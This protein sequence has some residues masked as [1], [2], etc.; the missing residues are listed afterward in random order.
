MIPWDFLGWGME[1]SGSNGSDGFFGWG[2]AAVAMVPMNLRVK[3]SSLGS[4][5]EG[6]HTD[7]AADHWPPQIS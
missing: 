4:E 3:V 6:H 5:R 7:A 2:F 1:R